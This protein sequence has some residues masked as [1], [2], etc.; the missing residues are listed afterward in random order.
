MSNTYSNNPVA[1]YPDSDTSEEPATTSFSLPSPLHEETESQLPE[2]PDDWKPPTE[3]DARYH[4]TSFCQLMVGEPT[5]EKLWQEVAQ[6]NG[7]K[8]RND[9]LFVH[10]LGI[11]V[12]TSEVSE[13]ACR[14]VMGFLTFF[15]MIQLNFVYSFTSLIS[16]FGA[17]FL[18]SLLQGWS[19]FVWTMVPLSSA[20]VLDDVLMKNVRRLLDGLVD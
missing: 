14:D 13:T 8:K 5:L 19:G 16:A 11:M 20:M 17:L 18:G 3:P 6:E 4:F 1:I 12:G 15:R 9:R 2:L 7:W 10:F